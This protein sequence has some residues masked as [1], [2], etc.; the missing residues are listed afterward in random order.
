MANIEVKKQQAIEV[1]EMSAEAWGTHD[2]SQNDLIIP[3]I[4][5]MQGLSVAVSDGKAVMGE[6]RC[7]LTN[8]LL[9]KAE[10]SSFEII[11]FMSQ[12]VFTIMRQEMPS[13]N[14]VY[15]R[16]DAIVKNP[17]QKGYNDNLPWE[18]TEEIDGR[19]TSIK[20]IRRYNFFCLLPSEIEDGSAMP[21][22]ISFKSTSVKEGK[23]LF[24]LMYIRN[25][26]A[27]LPPCAYKIK[28]DA[29]KTK[30]DKGTFYVPTVEQAD[31]TKQEHVTLAYEWFKRM[32]NTEVKLDE[33]EKDATEFN[34]QF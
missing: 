12:E 25:A 9:G 21:Y 24:N 17:M 14:F 26:S 31:K 18:D 6:F 11:P 3:Q 34:G 7:S 22:F 4:L 15:H 30:N 13:G 23:K 16:T 33:V 1:A 2:V 27:K 19:K 32:S 5:V 28:I 29:T 8:K 20:R 10:S